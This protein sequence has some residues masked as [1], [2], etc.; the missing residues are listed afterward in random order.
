MI[1][2][3]WMLIT[4]VAA[5]SLTAG[6]ASA[7]TIFLS[8]DT[9][10]RFTRPTDIAE[11]RIA[12]IEGTTG[13]GW[14]ETYN[15]RLVKTSDLEQAIQKVLNNQAEGVIFDV[16]AL[17]YY[18]SKNPDVPLKISEITF[19]SENYGFVLPFASPL[20]NELDIAIIALKE[21]GVLK[22]IHEEVLDL[23]GKN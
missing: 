22:E 6:L 1:T 18:L 11:Q 13:E 4:A 17:E 15:A 12:V 14:G 23:I 20:T 16:P 10:E 2:G 7:L 9:S 5:S 8:G 19:A 3:V 21:E